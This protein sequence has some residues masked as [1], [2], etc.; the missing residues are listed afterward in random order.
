MILNEKEILE[1]LQDSTKQIPVW[2]TNARVLNKELEALI[3][4]VDF[5]T[6]LYKVEHKE[7]DDQLLARKRYSHSIKDMFER[8]LRPID[9]VYTATGGTKRYGDKTDTNSTETYEKL[10]QSIATIRDQKPLEKWLQDNW[11]GHIYKTDPNG[12]ILYEYRKEKFYPTYK[13]I[14]SI[15]N[16][17]SDGQNLEW[18]LFEGI[19]QADKTIEW[20]LIDDENDYI[21]IQ[22]TASNVTQFA[23]NKEKSFNH[24]FGAVPGIINSDIIEL[25]TETRKSPIDSILELAK[26]SLRD[27]SHKSMFK[28]LLWDPIFWRYAQKCPQCGGAKRT[29]T[30]VCDMCNG[31]GIYGKKDITDIIQFGVPEDKETPIITPNVAGWLTPDVNIMAE[32]NKEID[33]LEDKIFTTIWGTIN[34]SKL[35]QNQKPNQDKTATEIIY[36]TAPQIARLNKFADSA[37]WVEWRL[38]ELA[39]NFVYQTK[40]KEQSIC[41]I[42]YGRNYIIE[43]LEILLNRY[44]DSVTNGLNSSICDKNLEEYI[45]S[46]FKTDPAGLEEELKRLKVEPFIHFTVEQVTKNYGQEEAKEKMLFA[47]WWHN[48]A[49]KNKEAEELI[50][51]FEAYCNEQLSEKE[52][53]PTITKNI[54]IKKLADGT[55]KY[56]NTE[57]NEEIADDALI[58]GIQ[59]IASERI[60]QL[61]P[62]ADF[63]LGYSLKSGNFE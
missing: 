16:Y 52:E 50:T 46:K 59:D 35:Y 37:Q 53:K 8:V 36:D 19:N 24:P 30:E 1:I 18:I 40:K 51:D 32:F 20:R 61:E 2:I 56:F 62:N 23:L 44:K 45:Y 29:G 5:N 60:K 17:K 11:M 25:G 39:A 34:Y 55:V 4:G 7:N 28:F 63:G 6:L 41:S 21:Y 27:E 3:N 15:R 38:T 43:P 14:S 58:Q 48:F 47:G 42:T 12:V 54:T 9:N 26:E 22:Q 49:D 10:I 13:N 57:S 33:K 31:S